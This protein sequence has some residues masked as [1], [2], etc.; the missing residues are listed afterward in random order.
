LLV[1]FAYKVFKILD[2]ADVIISLSTEVGA[3]MGA[4]KEMLVTDTVIKIWKYG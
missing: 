1:L 2:C 4:Q 3:N